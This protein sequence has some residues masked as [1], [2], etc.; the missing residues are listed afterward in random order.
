MIL[1]DVPTTKKIMSS[2][3]TLYKRNTKILKY[4]KFKNN[5]PKMKAILL[6]FV[7]ASLSCGYDAFLF[8]TVINTIGTVQGHV[9]N[10]INTVT[11]V[12]NIANLG[13]QFLWDNALKPA[14]DTFTSSNIRIVYF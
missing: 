12:A 14:L 1:T 7:I 3:R 5:L 2:Q 13:S 9:N 10:T 6:I 8:D 11:N 4:S